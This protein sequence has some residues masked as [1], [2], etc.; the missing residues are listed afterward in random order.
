I[1]SYS[2]VTSTGPESPSAMTPPSAVD[3]TF[4]WF[5]AVRSTAPSGNRKNKPKDDV[6]SVPRPDQ[7]NA[8]GMPQW[9]ASA[10]QVALPAAMPPWKT[11]MVMAST[12]ARTQS[13]VRLS[14]ST[15]KREMNT[16]QDAPPAS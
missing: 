11:S 14:T 8:E 13:G 15:L 5:H 7:N 10:P 4:Q 12:R 1:A 6:A 2:I 16:I 3:G 9:P